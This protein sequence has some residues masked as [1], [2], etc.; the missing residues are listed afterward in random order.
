MSKKEYAESKNAAFLAGLKA[1]REEGSVRTGDPAEFATAPGRTAER[2]ER[3]W[4]QEQLTLARKSEIELDLL[5]E[6]KG[7]RRALTPN[8]FGA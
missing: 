6:A 8:Q 5:R 2:Q 1:R 7:R 3:E 4:L